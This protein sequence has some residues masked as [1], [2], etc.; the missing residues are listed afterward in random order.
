MVIHH[1]PRNEAFVFLKKKEGGE[2]KK[3]SHIDLLEL[4]SMDK[5][6]TKSPAK[7]KLEN[8]SLRQKLGHPAGLPKLKFKRFFPGKS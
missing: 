3:K 2:R 7:S 8:K 6:E 1:R 5:K 4:E